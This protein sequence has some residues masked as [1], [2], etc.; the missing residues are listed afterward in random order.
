MPNASSAP[1]AA[2]AIAAPDYTDAY[3]VAVP[4]GATTDPAAWTRAIF[5]RTAFP[6]LAASDTE[7]LTGQTMP[8]LEFV[9]SVRVVDARVTLTTVVRYRNALG[10]LYFFVVRP[11]HRRLVPRMLTRAERRMRHAG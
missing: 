7:H 2:A 6:E 4:P 11:F 1:L 9:A 10:R 8:M 5:G 3:S